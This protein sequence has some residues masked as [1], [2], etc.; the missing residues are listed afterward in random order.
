MLNCFNVWYDLIQL[1]LKGDAVFIVTGGG[2]GIGRALALALADRGKSVLIVGRR[3]T[4]LKET[5]A[6]SS[7][8]NYVCADVSTVQGLDAINEFCQ[9]VARIEGLVN[10]AGVIEPIVAIKDIERTDWLQALSTNLN[11]ALFLTQKLYDK[12][13]QGRVLNISSGVAY[14]P[15]K[16]WA[17]YCVT[18]AALSMLTRCWQVE[19]EQVAF[20]SV[21]PG[22]IDTHM[23]ELARSDLNID[24]SQTTF[25]KQLKDSNRLLTV[26][27][28][29]QFL[30]WLMLDVNRE[31][32]GAQE[33]DIYE[34]EHH[35]E[36]LKP[37][38]QV[39]HW[40]P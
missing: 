37:P 33:W 4:Q 23:Q 12:L 17:A 35:K 8:I 24:K 10:N 26:E 28:V 11:P 20:A 21:M 3:A 13:H 32:Y 30:T 31:R 25:Y 22:I 39:V 5:A 27:T 16:G 6:V 38:H 19:S 18:K 7:L 29:A 1:C 2:S 36:W 15:I 34:T 14:F 40:E 9:S